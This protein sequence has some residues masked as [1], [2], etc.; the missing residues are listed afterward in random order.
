MDIGSFLPITSFF[1]NQIL[2][3]VKISGLVLSHKI[4]EL[5]DKKEIQNIL[6]NIDNYRIS[7]EKYEDFL[8]YV[9]AKIDSDQIWLVRFGSTTILML[10]SEY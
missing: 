1:F 2:D 3:D 6:S 8:I 10:S 7:Y 9:V 5:F 4:M